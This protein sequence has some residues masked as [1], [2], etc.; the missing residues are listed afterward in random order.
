MRIGVAGLGRMGAAMAAR[1]IDRGH[2]V[3]VWNRTSK[4]AAPLVAAGAKEAASPAA[5][6]DQAEIVITML[7]DQKAADEVYRGPAGLL[8]GNV[9]GKLLIDMSTVRPSEVRATAKAARE[10]G[11]AFVECPVGGTIGP[12]RNGQ[13]LGFAGGEAEDFARAKPVLDELCRRVDLV[14]PLGAG[15]AIK[16]AINLPL[17]VFWQAFGEANAL[18]GDLGGDPQFIVGLF[19]ESSG[20]ANV[21]RVRGPAVAAALAGKGPAEVAFA[22]AGIAKDLR[23]MVEEAEAK[24]FDL[25]VVRRTL[26]VCEQMVKAGWGDRDASWMPAFWPA[27]VAGKA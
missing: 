11:A 10:A 22:I 3:I 17:L 2:E 7:F 15:A 21:L 25:P 5:L 8:S 26:E 23:L 1:L 18:I 14:G 20:G 27:Y 9:R 12:A 4:R 6:A 24:G 16:L 19:A 13:L